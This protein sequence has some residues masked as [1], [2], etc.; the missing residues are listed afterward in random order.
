MD[1]G[2]RP[3]VVI[4]GMVI[5]QPVVGQRS[6]EV[7]VEA[8]VRQEAGWGRAGAGVLQGGPEEGQAGGGARTPLRRQVSMLS[9]DAAMGDMGSSEE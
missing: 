2:F 3:E 7:E 8:S 5:L 6:L 4:G 1:Q 9:A